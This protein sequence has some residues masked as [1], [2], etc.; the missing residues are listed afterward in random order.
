MNRDQVLE[1]LCKLS[2][3]YPQARRTPEELDFLADEWAE[4]LAKFDWAVVDLAYKRYRRASS[5]FP[6]I[7]EI[8]QRC[9]EVE[10]E[11][12]REQGRLALPM[13]VGVSPERAKWWIGKILQR[14][15]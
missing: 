9:R 11:K 8:L 6:T 10:E 5:F 1:L 3:L 15:G 13:A 14:K 7:A 2:I 4:D 12:E